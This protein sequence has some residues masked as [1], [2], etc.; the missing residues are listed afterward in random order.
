VRITAPRGAHER[1]GHEKFTLTEIMK[2]EEQILDLVD[3]HDN[4][5]R[6]D[7]RSTDLD[8]LSAD[9]ARAVAA[10]GS[11]PWLV[12]PLCAPAGAGKTHS[13]RALRTAAARAG[14]DVLV[15]A[16]TGKAVDEALH[17]DAGDRG[18]TIAK[19]LHL[20]QQG[21]LT[22][23]RHCVIVVDEASM[24]AT[25]DLKTLLTETTKA[26]VKTVLVGD[27]YQLSP[28]KARGGMFE[29]LSDELLD[30]TT[31]RGLAHD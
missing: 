2:E 5:S 3:A 16:P 17:D 19:A 12:A 18:Y 15:L 25:P 24:V 23:D 10:I 27:P 6:L 11:A 30:P 26:R 1:E 9:Q 4:T 31:L 21:D 28:V 14:K 22:L 20:M 13:L 8:A 7:V 29:Q